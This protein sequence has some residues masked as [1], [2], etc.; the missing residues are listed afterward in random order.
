[1]TTDPKLTLLELLKGGWSLPYEPRFSADWYQAKQDLP[2]VTVTHMMTGVEPLGF[3]DDV[4]ASDRRLNAVYLV[5]VWSMGDSEKRW[6]MLTEV[7]RIL[8]SRMT[9]P[10]GGLDSLSVSAWRD[11]D[12]GHLTPPLYRSQVQ[13][14]VHYYG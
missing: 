5:D 10:G 12:E 3:S 11:L 2:Q 9:E 6:Q 14:E 4:P 8:K 13:V 1:M 7:D